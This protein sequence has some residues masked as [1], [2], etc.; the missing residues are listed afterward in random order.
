MKPSRLTYLMIFALAMSLAATGC[1]H[2]PVD[3]TTFPGRRPTPPNSGNPTPL[4]SGGQLRG[5][6]I[7]TTGVPLPEDFNDLSKFEQLCEILVPHTVHFDYDSL[8]VK[9]SEQPHVQA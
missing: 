7:L 6:E 3:V 8:V 9:S 5:N 2:K 1:K 4:V